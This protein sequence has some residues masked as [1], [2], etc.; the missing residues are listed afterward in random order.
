MCPTGWN[1]TPNCEQGNDRA[2][3]LHRTR[4][5]AESRGFPWKG[6]LLLYLIQKKENRFGVRFLCNLLCCLGCSQLWAERCLTQQK[7]ESD[8]MGGSL[9]ANYSAKWGSPRGNLPSGAGLSHVGSAN[10]S[11]PHLWAPARGCG[12][13]QAGGHSRR[14]TENYT[15]VIQQERDSD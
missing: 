5:K 10:I 1:Q 11:L 12:Q 14:A 3:E 6:R 13:V 15:R 8:G 4:K 7:R 9:E 2:R